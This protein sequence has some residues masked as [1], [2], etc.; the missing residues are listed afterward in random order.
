[1]SKNSNLVSTDEEKA[2]VLSN[3]FTSVFIGSLSPN[4][5]EL[6]DHKMGTR[7]VKTLTL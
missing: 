2:K 5:P 4:P 1:M 7:G 6:M 3:F